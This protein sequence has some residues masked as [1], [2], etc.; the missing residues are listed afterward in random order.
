MPFPL[1]D[2]KSQ[3][4]VTVTGTQRQSSLCGGPP[5]GSCDPTECNLGNKHPNLISSFP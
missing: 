3:R 2:L 5:D 1:V 4:E